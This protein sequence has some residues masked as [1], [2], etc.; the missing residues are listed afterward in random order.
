MKET[1]FAYVMDYEE[2]QA[3]ESEANKKL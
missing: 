2:Q 1:M 3:D